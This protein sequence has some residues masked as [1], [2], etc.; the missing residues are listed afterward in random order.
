MGPRLGDGAEHLSSPLL[1]AVVPPCSQRTVALF[2]PFCAQSPLVSGVTENSFVSSCFFQHFSGP[3]TLPFAHVELALLV[4]QRGL[5]FS[6]CFVP[7]SPC[8]CP[9][10][11]ASFYLHRW[12]C[13]ARWGRL[14]ARVSR[15]SVAFV[16]FTECKPFDHVFCTRTAT[17]SLRMAQPV[18]CAAVGPGSGC[19]GAPPG[20]RGRAPFFSIASGRCSAVLPTD[21]CTFR[22]FLC[23]E[24]PSIGGHGKFICVFLLLS[25]L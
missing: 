6:W 14:I 19:D 21:R 15:C 5:V 11:N 23:S 22:S 1:L 24:P 7:P 18:L 12:M 25:A 17:D 9:I 4:G 13:V 16:L 20:G 10:E 3:S 8:V 2:A